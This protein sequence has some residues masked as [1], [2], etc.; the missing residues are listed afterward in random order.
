MAKCPN[1][2]HPDYKVLEA[3]HGEKGAFRMYMENRYDI[4][5]PEN[6]SKK[7]RFGLKGLVFKSRDTMEA[8]DKNPE[9]AQE[10]IDSLEEIMPNVKV[11][12]DGM[13]DKDG[14]WIEIAP[15]EK[16]M[17]YR[18]AFQGAV[19]WANDAYMETPPHEYAH[20]YID[21]F[22][23]LPIVKRGIEKYGEEQ[24]VKRMGAYYAKRK[25]SNSFQKFVQ[26]FWAS[27]KSF[28]GN[29]NVSDIL[30]SHF[31]KGD[32]LDGPVH[33]GTAIV[34]YQKGNKILKPTNGGV[35]SDGQY[36]KDDIAPAHEMSNED[37]ANK[38][39]ED[40]INDE[41]F[42]HDESDIAKS[43]EAK[44]INTAKLGL[45]I[46]N[47]INRLRK[48][49]RTAQKLEKNAPHTD[50][51]L[52]ED[53]EEVADNS[54][55]LNNIAKKL[56]G[57]E[58]LSTVKVAGEEK[59]TAVEL[60]AEE[61]KAFDTILAIEKR[62]AYKELTDNS[63]FDSHG[64]LINKEAVN[65]SISNEV[66]QTA[67]RRKALYDKIPTEAL[68]KIFRTIEKMLTDWQGNARLITKYL[69]GGENT[70]L[71]DMMYKSLNQ[72]NKTQN[73]IKQGFADI[74]K[75]TE[76]IPGFKNWSIH[77]KKG[78]TIDEIDTVDVT[79]ADGKVKLS[80]AEYLGLYLNLRQSDSKAAI[81]NKG[82][83]IDEKVKGRSG[84]YN[85][86]H[87]VT[88]TEIL[89][90]TSS[91]ESDPQMMEVVKK[92]D[93][94]FAYLYEQTNETFKQEYGYDLENRPNYFPG[95]PGKESIQ[96]RKRESS[97]DEFRAGN[98]RMGA[99]EPMRISDAFQ[100]INNA[101]NTGA[102]YAGYALPVSNI[103]KLIASISGDYVNQDENKYF[104][105]LEGVVN[106]IES[107]GQIFGSEGEANF[108]QKIN[109]LTSN[110]AVAVLGMNIPVM[111]KQPVSYITAKEEIDSKY[112]KK[113]GWGA[114]GFVGINPMK[115]I[116]SLKWTGI[117]GG[118]TWL[119][120]EWSL[121][122][123]NDAVYDEMMKDPNARA[124]LEG[125]F[126]KEAGEALL[127]NEIGQDK[128]GL[129]GLKVKGE[130]VEVSKA[131]LME[132][133]KI[134]DS[135]TVMSIWKA[136]KFETAEQHKELVE[137]TKEYEEHVSERWNDII[138]K[139]QPTYDA[140]NRSVLSLSK[141]P[142]A[143]MFSIFGS[144]R[145]KVAM[146][147]IDGAISYINNPSPENAK[148]LYKRSINVVLLTSMALAAVDVLKGGVLYGYDDDDD[149]LNMIGL[150]M[151][152][153][154]F[155]NFYGISD[156]TS[157]IMSQM[158][159]KPWHKNMQTPVEVLGQ[160]FSE[161]ISHAFKG[162]F[163][164]AFEK[165]LSVA[166][167]STGLPMSVKTYTKAAYKQTA[168]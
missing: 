122:I 50:S 69:S 159:D 149:Y 120:L 141:N 158:D 41:A 160:E 3:R 157:L 11:H 150:S 17:H 142:I 9:V 135:V 34:R 102:T 82:F 93:E 88:A 78:T 107:P 155:G 128:I 4:P 5:V 22:R 19:A 38:F 96:S 33:K 58:T 35:N 106:S 109:R 97:L 10:I 152:A 52:L 95:T 164:K 68:K 165:S 140:A 8:M 1:K 44:N 55:Q 105:S 111:M 89:N 74:F 83:I 110:F 100:V 2:A 103:R 60:T 127:N 53:L 87:Q 45:L 29:S 16:G 90:I 123:K 51:R 7:I 167:K 64:N 117:E 168:Q 80:R 42:V 56:L 67:L 26:D 21:M 98:A 129:L 130:K 13:F 137:G 40:A 118:E 75:S 124:R 166:L 47:K 145:S 116:K 37:A 147:M 99:N 66:S 101:K 112:L 139:T 108:A 14:N 138:N 162:N 161:A 92:I 132:G 85:K 27:I 46:R 81:M 104:K 146:L 121:D 73:K 148:I 25:M 23:E 125:E 143:R 32:M 154:N 86:A 61:Q 28:L 31:Y 136:V 30:S 63:Y 49:D 119:P 48:I 39:Q 153:T 18:N 144:A 131:R 43:Q 57:I 72:G 156:I 114:A 24:L 151:I 59:T 12:K 134:F 70:E 133:I 20:E 163:S 6:I 115:I 62:F 65:I 94:A 84:Q 15:G 71:S 77:N 36:E 76:S 113:A 91:V 126:S 54:E 79:T